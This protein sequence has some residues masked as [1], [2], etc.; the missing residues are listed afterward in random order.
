[1]LLINEIEALQLIMSIWCFIIRDGWLFRRCMLER[2]L[3]SCSFQVRVEFLRCS[4]QP[5]ASKREALRLW[6]QVLVI[7]VFN[8]LISSSK[9]IILKLSLPCSK[10]HSSFSTIIFCCGWTTDCS[11]ETLSSS[12]QFVCCKVEIWLSYWVKVLSYWEIWS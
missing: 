10:I 11:L 3:S 1:M 12:F 2:F 5:W 6:Q 8:L 9:I 4:F 7:F